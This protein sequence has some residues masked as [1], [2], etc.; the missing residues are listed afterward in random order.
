MQENYVSGTNYKPRW[1]WN[2][3]YHAK[4]VNKKTK[5]L[6]NFKDQF[7]IKKNE[8]RNTIDIRSD[9]FSFGG[10]KWAAPGFMIHLCL[11]IC[12]LWWHNIGVSFSSLLYIPHG[13]YIKFL[14]CLFAVHLV[15]TNISRTR[16]GR[17]D[18][19]YTKVHT[20]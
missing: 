8:N 1:K 6:D 11:F 5:M 2:F 14:E 7:I 4:I 16:H 10:R 9:A 19:T 3:L 20:F 17:L 13:L 18:Y 15:Y 12:A